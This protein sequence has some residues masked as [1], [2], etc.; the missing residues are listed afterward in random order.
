[1]QKSKSA[2]IIKKFNYQNGPK[3]RENPV[4]GTGSSVDKNVEIL[5]KSEKNRSTERQQ[6]LKNSHS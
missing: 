5:L 3:M 4:S 1:M 6:K 2:G